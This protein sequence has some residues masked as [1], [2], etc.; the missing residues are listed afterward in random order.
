MLPGAQ[1]FPQD[2][3]IRRATIPFFV[4][5]LVPFL[6]FF[7]G[8]TQRAL[9][10]G[11]VLYLVRVFFITAGYHR[12]FAHRAFRVGRVTQAVLAFGGATAVQKGPLWWAGH[13]R[14]H[15][16]YADTERDP[17]SPQR[18]FWWSHIGWIVSDRFEKTD[19][20]AIDDFARYPELRWLNRYSVVP[21]MMLAVASYLI[22]GWSGLVVGFF[23]STVLLWHATFA[24]NSVAHLRGT[25]RFATTDSSRNNVVLALATLG[26]GWHNNHHHNPRTARQGLRWW[27]LDV[28]YLIL[29]MLQ[30]VRIVHDLREPPTAALKARRVKAGAHDVGLMRYHLSRAAK[31][32]SRAAHAEQLVQLLESTAQQ[33][34]TVA[35]QQGDRLSSAARDRSRSPEVG[36]STSEG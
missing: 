1:L 32:A 26:E 6:A 25:R 15:H 35:R 11:V 29:R 2:V 7:T 24:I 12:Y 27:E 34:A 8:V 33:L 17:H 21:P 10:L 22:A 5:H 19:Y 36:V 23:G 14:A 16:K 18:G 3:T 20:D 9:V 30:R 13:H 28:T 31:V 4:A